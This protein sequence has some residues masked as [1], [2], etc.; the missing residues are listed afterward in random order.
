MCTPPPSAAR[1]SGGRVG[2]KVTSGSE[3][4]LD[5][6]KS[7]LPFSPSRTQS[8]SFAL[9]GIFQH[10]VHSFLSTFYTVFNICVFSLHG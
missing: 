4:S 7:S 5:R 8:P 6:L 1:R 2:R 9:P 10:G 3:R